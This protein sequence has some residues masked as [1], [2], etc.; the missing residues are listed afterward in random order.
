M[1][2]RAFREFAVDFMVDMSMLCIGLLIGIA[3]KD[4]VTI[5]F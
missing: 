4:L 1:N 2:E 3:L 5:L